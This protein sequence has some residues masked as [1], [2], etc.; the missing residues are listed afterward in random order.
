[1]TRSPQGANALRASRVRCFVSLLHRTTRPAL[2]ACAIA[3][4]AA[5]SS[6]PSS[7]SGADGGATPTATASPAV[8]AASAAAST[9]LSNEPIEAS[10]AFIVV[11]G[12]A[13][14][15]CASNI[16]VQL[17]RIPGVQVRNVDMKN[18]L[19]R[20]AFQSTPHPSTTQL[21][22]AVEDAGL[23]WR[24]WISAADEGATP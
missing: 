4:L 24:G 5:C 8:V 20:V 15:K 3:A 17:T 6:T 10:A 22:R 19:V 9:S 18:G 16:D 11:A 23:T 12:L 13:C 2:L 1:M 7:T 21:A 14:P